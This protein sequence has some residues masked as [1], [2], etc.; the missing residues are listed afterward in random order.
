MSF[1]DECSAIGDLATI[2]LL[3]AN[4]EPLKVLEFHE[5][6]NYGPIGTVR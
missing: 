4:Y 2:I 5:G 3:T 6:S 1:A